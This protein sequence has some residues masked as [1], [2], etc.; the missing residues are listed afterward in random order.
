MA[1]EVLQLKPYSFSSDVYS[2]GVVLYEL[3][4]RESYIQGSTMS[5]LLTKHMVADPSQA[6]QREC[7]MHVPV[8]IARIVTRML[9]ANPDDRPTA[10][11]LMSEPVIQQ[12][13]IALVEGIKSRL[14]CSG[15]TMR[16][17]SG[18]SAAGM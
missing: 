8:S 5:S 15:R 16:A 11:E 17:S 1:P 12:G 10:N 7:G 9:A 14:E 13:L 4:T 6:F 2:L 3:C 18:S